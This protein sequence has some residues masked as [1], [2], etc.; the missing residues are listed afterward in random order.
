MKSFLILLALICL[1]IAE[2]RTLQLSDNCANALIGA[3]ISYVYCVEDK[4]DD[5][6]AFRT[7]IFLTEDISVCLDNEVK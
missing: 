4:V 2:D 3:K 6:P 7:T 5:K 1:G